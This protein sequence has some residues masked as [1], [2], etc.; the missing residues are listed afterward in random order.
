MMLDYSS[1]GHTN[2]IARKLG[3]T[4]QT[5]FSGLAGFEYLND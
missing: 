3:Q 4:K 2:T 5:P 1:E